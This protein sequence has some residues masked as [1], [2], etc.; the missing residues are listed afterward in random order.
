[1]PT[2]EDVYE[3]ITTFAIP[4][5][6]GRERRAVLLHPGG[7]APVPLVVSPTPMGFTAT[8]I[9]FG[10]AAG[11][12][13][14]LDFP[15]LW[16]TALDRGVAVLSLESFGA[17]LPA[18]SLAWPAHI[19]AYGTAIETARTMVPID[20]ARIVAC[21]ISMGGLES[22][23]LAGRLSPLI[24]AVAIQN[25]PF[26]LVALH[27][28]TDDGTRERLEIEVGGDPVSAHRSYL[29]RGAAQ[30]LDEL[31]AIGVHIRLNDTDGVVAAKTQGRVLA[32]MLTAAGG[33]VE[34]CEDE[35]VVPPGV[36]GARAAHEH[37]SWSA[38]L[39]FVLADRP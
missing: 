12:R 25:A 32:A 16:P 13:T 34:V 38:L 27:D 5:S 8:A 30:Y 1:M 18:A 39:D 20:G 14:A 4:S 26:D 33:L 28:A 31:A 15:G 36:D 21:G 17:R 3:T 35:P 7:D 19:A 10:S 22:L 2:S 11:R 29:E 24:R 37:I 6:D 9:L 23:V